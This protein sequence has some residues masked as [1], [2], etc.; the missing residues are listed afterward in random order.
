MVTPRERWWTRALER[1]DLGL[2]VQCGGHN[3]Q[4]EDENRRDSCK[5]KSAESSRRSRKGA[6]LRRI[7]KAAVGRLL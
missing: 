4:P 5:A 3:D 6:K 2:C 1:I 7:E